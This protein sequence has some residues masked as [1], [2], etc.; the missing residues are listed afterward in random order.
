MAG[1]GWPAHPAQAALI[2][3]LCRLHENGADTEF[4]TAK[5]DV[6]YACEL[7]G[8]CAANWRGGVTKL[9]TFGHAGG[10]G[11]MSAP[12]AGDARA[13]QSEADKKHAAPARA[14]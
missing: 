10:F 6:Q 4:A 14:R 5:H 2:D 1:T 9:C 11:L 7:L 12:R 8:R 13:Q 3:R